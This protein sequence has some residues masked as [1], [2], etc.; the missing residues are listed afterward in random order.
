MTTPRLVSPIVG[1]QFR[2]PA[3]LLLRVLPTNHPL[4]LEAEPSNEYDPDAIRVL[5]SH[6]TLDL[7]NE[8]IAQILSNTHLANQAA[9]DDWV[10]NQV[11]HIGYVARSG[12]TRS[13]QIDNRPSIGNTEI[14]NALTHAKAIKPLT[15]WRYPA[16]LIFSMSGQPLIEVKLP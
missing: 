6:T 16:N 8:Q 11:L 7:D 5:F 10:N 15:T 3:L 12:N 13:C 4:I 1:A 14:T 2:P 9:T